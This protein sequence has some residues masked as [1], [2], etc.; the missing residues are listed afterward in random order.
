MAVA[1]PRRTVRLAVPPR[2]TRADRHFGQL[3]YL[4]GWWY[5]AA[6]CLDFPG[7]RVRMPGD[8]SGPSAA[9]RETLIAI[10]RDAATLT[11]QLHPHL[12]AEHIRAREASEGHA[13]RVARCGD[14]LHE[15][16][17]VEAMCAAPFGQERMVELAI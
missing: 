7:V 2:A 1:I 13:V 3:A 10:E 9:A 4:H 15:H 5:G 11:R 16:Y 14:L 17:R 6:V 8:V 12:W